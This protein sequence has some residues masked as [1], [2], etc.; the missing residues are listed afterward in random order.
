[1][2]TNIIQAFYSFFLHF[3]PTLNFFAD[4]FR[5]LLD[6]HENSP[7]KRPVFHEGRNGEKAGSHPGL[8]KAETKGEGGLNVLNQTFQTVTY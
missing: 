3:E 8:H 4:Q 2:I 5:I 1:M 7:G 6:N